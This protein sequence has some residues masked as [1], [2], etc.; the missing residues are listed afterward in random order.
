MGRLYQFAGL[1]AGNPLILSPHSSMAS[2]IKA[3]AGGLSSYFDEIDSSLDKGK[4]IKQS[5]VKDKVAPIMRRLVVSS[6]MLGYSHAA[7]VS[8]KSMPA[9]YGKDVRAGAEKRGAKVDKLMRR[10]TKRTLKNVPDSEYILSAS[11]ALAAAEYEASR[12]YFR[13]VRD[14]LAG[15]GMGKSW[16][17]ASGESC[18]DCLGNEDEDVIGV[19][20]MFS[21]GHF[22]PA[23]HLHCACFIQL[24][25]V[26]S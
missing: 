2:Q 1:E 11:R 23:A 25:K 20:E 4:G 24:R 13:G 17:T 9:L 8:K 12:A 10:T 14:A 5:I 19:D 16:V 21:S 22:Y 15:S 7:K 18:E 6:R 3:A 26:K